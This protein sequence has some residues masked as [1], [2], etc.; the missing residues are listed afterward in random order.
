MTTKEAEFTQR[1][2]VVRVRAT[3]QLTLPVGCAVFIKGE[4]PTWCELPEL[5]GASYRRMRAVYGIFLLSS[6]LF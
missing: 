1:R 6:S 5:P 2:E 4:T 3:C